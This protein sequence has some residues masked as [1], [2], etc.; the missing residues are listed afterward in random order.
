MIHR[1]L[2]AL[3]LVACA[4]PV[5]AQTAAPPPRIE[6]IPR[7]AFY[8]TLE[9]L[10]GEADE[11]YRWLNALHLFGRGGVADGGVRYDF[12]QGA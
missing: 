9:H 11:R 10:W 5:A 1:F 12:F 3:A 4:A 8:M 7:T 2:V 6:F